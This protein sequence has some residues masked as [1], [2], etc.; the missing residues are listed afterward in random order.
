MSVGRVR[1]LLAMA[2]FACALLA[3]AFEDHRLG[4]L[5]IALLAASLVARLV[6]RPPR[7]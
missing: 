4:W 3:I 5:A 1:V 7:V 6:W 2:G